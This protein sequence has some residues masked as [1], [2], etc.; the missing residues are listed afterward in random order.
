M[1]I[2]TTSGGLNSRTLAPSF[3]SSISGRLLDLGL[4]IADKVI[5]NYFTNKFSGKTQTNQTSSFKKQR[6]TFKYTSSKYRK[7]K[8]SKR[9][10]RVFHRSRYSKYNRR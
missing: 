1:T 7:R 9:P 8:Y 2:V 3:S 6:K 4:G 10:Y 5:T